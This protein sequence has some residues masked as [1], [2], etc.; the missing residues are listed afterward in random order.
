MAG[1]AD[2]RDLTAAHQREQVLLGLAAEDV[3]DELSRLLAPNDL[4]GSYPRWAAA[5]VDAMRASHSIG[6]REAEAYLRAY[7][8]VEAV[9]LDVG[10]MPIVR[11]EFDLKRTYQTFG[12][13]LLSVRERIESGRSPEAAVAAALKD[14]RPR[15]SKQAM[16]SGRDLIGLSAGANELSSGWR[17]VP[18]SDPCTWCAMLVT[19]GPVYDK[20]TVTAQRDGSKYH[21][22]C[23]CTAEEV[24]GEWQP[25]AREQE[26]IDAYNA[27]HEPGMSAKETMAA[28]RS[29]TGGTGLFRDSRSTSPTGAL[30]DE[31]RAKSTGLEPKRTDL[32]HDGM[33]GRPKGAVKPDLFSVAELRTRGLIASEDKPDRHYRYDSERI[34]AAWQA[35]IGQPVLSVKDINEHGKRTPDAVLIGL[36]RTVEFKATKADTDNA[37]IQ[38]VRNARGQSAHIVIDARQAGLTM[39][40]AKARMELALLRYGAD[41]RSLDVIITDGEYVH[42]EL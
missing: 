13:V 9:G 34:I 27:A 37:I 3:F 23:G 33:L 8:A 20:T 40:Q 42:W 22:N 2:G 14:L 35:R 30:F 12:W 5:M 6:V 10:D 31:K 1:T 25:T 19:R 38:A 21:N 26:Y 15:W 32:V 41:V 24:F 29:E 7:R 17:R 39:G 16:A 28:M 11:P 36:T 18:D 4:D